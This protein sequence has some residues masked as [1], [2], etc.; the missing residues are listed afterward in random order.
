MS[1]TVAQFLLGTRGIHRDLDAFVVAVRFDRASRTAAFALGDGS[2]HLVSVADKANWRKIE[3]HDGAALALSPDASPTGFISGGDD[4][5]FRRIGDDDAVGAIA[6]F[7]MKWVE[8]V[9]S[10]P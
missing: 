6:D 8:H 10:H 3:V 2:L 7:R 9:A 4:G 5:T 1:D